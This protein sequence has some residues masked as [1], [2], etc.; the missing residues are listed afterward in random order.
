MWLLHTQDFEL[1]QRDSP[2]F[3]EK[4][5]TVY[6]ENNDYAI[7]SHRWV[8]QEITFNQIKAHVAELK[9]RKPQATL[10]LEKIRRSCETAQSLGFDWIWIDTCCINKTS[11]TELTESLNSMFSW[12]REA[13]L[14]ITYLNDVKRPESSAKSDY[15]D[16]GIP[17]H[18][19]KENS[20]EPSVW[21]SRGWTLQELLAP[22]EM[23]F[24]DMNWSDLGTKA[25]LVNELK[26]VTGIEARYLRGGNTFR[27]ACI[28]TKISWMAERTTERVEDM[29]Y[30]MLGIFGIYMAPQYGERE[31]AFVRLQ[32]ELLSKSTDESLFAWRMPRDGAGGTTGSWA[33]DAWAPDE[34]GLL[35]PHPK[36]FKGSQHLTINGEARE[37]IPRPLGGF[38]TTQQGIQIP[39]APV[40]IKK[41][42]SY[43]VM[44]IPGV[45][46][47]V[48]LALLMAQKYQAS[49]RDTFPLNCWQPDKFG[50][51]VR[52]QL[53]LR[54]CSKKSVVMKRL[55]CTEFAPDEKMT[56]SKYNTD[57][58]KKCMVLQPEQD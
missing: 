15:S 31:L 7:L 22:R 13:K 28:A 37:I 53:Y 18:F 47:F 21:F 33:L 14:C 29:A 40:V 36:W 3:H 16:Q 55:R 46:F 1:Y 23:R 38:S 51:M 41:R 8:G 6:Q 52:V 48:G 20:R 42:Y 45:N 26:E 24:Y 19:K 43:P 50:S 58:A 11:A 56:F 17:T 49:H 44:M 57:L 35:A 54:P 2:S 27:S 12:Y 10:Q 39:V 34:W 5:S 4:C 25:E 32:Q 9:S 30:S